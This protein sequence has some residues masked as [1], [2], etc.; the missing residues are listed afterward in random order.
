MSDGWKLDREEVKLPWISIS[1][2]VVGMSKPAIPPEPSW[3]NWIWVGW[4]TS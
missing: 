3:M 1:S 4:L 2:F